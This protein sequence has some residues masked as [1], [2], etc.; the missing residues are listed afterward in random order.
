MVEYPTFKRRLGAFAIDAIIVYIAL[1]PI[2]FLTWSLP[3]GDAVIVMIAI[4]LLWNAYLIVPQ[5]L[6]G[7]TVGKKV[8]KVHLRE[9]TGGPVQWT[10]VLLR[11]SPNVLFTV[12]SF[13]GW[14]LTVQTA[15][16]DELHAASLLERG[17]LMQE[18]GPVWAGQ[19]LTWVMIGWLVLNAIVLRN[20]SQNRA[21][22]DLIAGTIVLHRRDPS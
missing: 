15:G 17:K 14:F 8:V 19:S 5:A 4:G 16:W 22:H 18:A 6:W 20:S 3:F 21:L 13:I 1:G 7:Q 9:K 11:H 2:S 10:P 12:A